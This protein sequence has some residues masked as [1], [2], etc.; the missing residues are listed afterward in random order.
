MVTAYGVLLDGREMW[1]G[2]PKNN[3]VNKRNIHN[4]LNGICERLPVNTKSEEID[5]IFQIIHSNGEIQHMSINIAEYNENIIES[6]K[7]L[8]S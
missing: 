5:F 4:F 6:I 2:F 7:D 8:P 1:C 3:T